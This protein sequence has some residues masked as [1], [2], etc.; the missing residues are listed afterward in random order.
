[1]LLVNAFYATNGPQTIIFAIFVSMNPP[2]QGSIEL[3]V[4]LVPDPVRDVN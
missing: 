2:K 1:M 4:V 3:N